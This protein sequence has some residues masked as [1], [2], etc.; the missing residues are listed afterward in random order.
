MVGLKI[1]FPCARIRQG[2]I[3]EWTTFIFSLVSTFISANKNTTMLI[4][5][6]FNSYSIISAFLV[7]LEILMLQHER[8]ES[9]RY[10]GVPPEAGI[11]ES[12]QTSIARQRLG[13]HV[14]CI[15]SCET[16]R[17]L[18]GS[19]RCSLL[20]WQDCLKEMQPLTE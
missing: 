20:G 3:I 19:T 18:K 5:D 14:S 4:A 13:N 12:L 2:V 16:I 7:I 17:K 8:K 15:T 1:F 9:L 10:C 6:L 11:S